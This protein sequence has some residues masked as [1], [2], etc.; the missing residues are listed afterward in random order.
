MAWKHAR[1]AARG[2]ALAVIAVMLWGV[3]QGV[4]A[5]SAPAENLQSGTTPPGP[6]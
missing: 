2:Q 5:I 6:Q 1:A 4:T 3:W